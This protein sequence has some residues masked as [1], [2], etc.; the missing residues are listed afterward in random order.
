MSTRERL[1][2]PV[3]HLPSFVG[4]LRVLALRA[5]ALA[6]GRFAHVG[7]WR[8]YRSLP[9]DFG[10]NRE[11]AELPG[12]HYAC[13]KCRFERRKGRPGA[14]RSVCAPRRGAREAR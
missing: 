1:Q 9:G 6:P 4:Q 11:L 12:S 3:R 2:F 10:R 5:G 13:G 8:V 7:E 14:A